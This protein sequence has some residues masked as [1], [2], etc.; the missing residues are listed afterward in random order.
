MLAKVFLCFSR[1]PFEF[2]IGLINGILE[3]SYPL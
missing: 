2:V 1:V 3:R